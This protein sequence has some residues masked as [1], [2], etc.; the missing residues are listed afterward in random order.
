MAIKKIIKRDGTVVPFKEER[1]FNAIHKAFLATKGE[2][3]VGITQRLTDQ[4]IGELNTR[5]HER[6]I[7]AIEDILTATL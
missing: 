1:I 2:P 3:C 5:Y 6:T 4:V 7:P